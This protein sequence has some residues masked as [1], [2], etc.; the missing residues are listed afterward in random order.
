[1][2]SNSASVSSF[3]SM[4]T[5]AVASGEA[6]EADATG[7][8]A[9]WASARCFRRPRRRLMNPSLSAYVWG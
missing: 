3:R 6:A 7:V 4:G 5:V 2:T 9:T 1:M 8:V